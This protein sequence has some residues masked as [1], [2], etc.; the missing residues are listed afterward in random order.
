MTE[1]MNNEEWRD[2]ALCAS[3]GD[4]E[5]FFPPSKTIQKGWTKE[6]ERQKK[7]SEARA[8]KICGRCAVA[9]ECLEY[10]LRLKVPA[11]IWGGLNEDERK[12]LQKKRDRSRRRRAS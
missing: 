9:N 7:E 1:I 5:D 8:K 10:S 6:D 2:Y 12:N 4:P 3:E 11:G